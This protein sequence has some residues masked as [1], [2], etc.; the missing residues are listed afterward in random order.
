VLILRAAHRVLLGLLALGAT[1]GR[2]QAHEIVSEA[3]RTTARTGA[4]FADVLAADPACASIS[5]SRRSR[6]CST[7]R[8]TRG[9]APR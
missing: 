1:V 3:T 6:P 5:T 7:L 2:Q 4:A 8:R 9:C